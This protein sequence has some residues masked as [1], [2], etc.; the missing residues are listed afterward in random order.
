MKSNLKIHLILGVLISAQIGVKWNKLQGISKRCYISEKCCLR[1]NEVSWIKH[2]HFF[3]ETVFKIER[4]EEGDIWA[5]VYTGSGM[6]W[7]RLTRRAKPAVTKTGEKDW[8]G[9]SVMR[10]LPYFKCHQKV[11]SAPLVSVRKL[12][13]KSHSEFGSYVG[14]KWQ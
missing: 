6:L 8:Q 11:T 10:T 13:H 2:S 5:Q 9:P 4:K 14:K 7:Y 3:Y 12:I 1:K